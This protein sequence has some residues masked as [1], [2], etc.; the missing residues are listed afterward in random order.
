MPLKQVTASNK[1]MQ[2]S[3]IFAMIGLF[4]LPIVLSGLVAHTFLSIKAKRSLSFSEAQHYS[5]M[6]GRSNI[7]SLLISRQIVGLRL[8]DVIAD[9]LSDRAI[10][11]TIVKAGAE[12]QILPLPPQ[13]ILASCDRI[14]AYVKP[15][16][17]DAAENPLG[18]MVPDSCREGAEYPAATDVNYFLTLASYEAIDQPYLEVALLKAGWIKKDIPRPGGAQTFGKG[19]V[20]IRIV[21]SSGYLFSDINLLV[22]YL[23]P[24]TRA[25]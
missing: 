20:R 12:Q 8:L 15:I 16:Q 1:P 17:N 22:L 23:L 18:L 4:L 24:G 7:G 11:Q 19:N 13:T 2:K 21:H 9:A 5:A 3:R 14:A 6:I 25:D 10:P